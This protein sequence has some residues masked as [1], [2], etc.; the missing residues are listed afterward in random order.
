MA[1]F[2]TEMNAHQLCSFKEVLVAC[3]YK[4][5]FSIEEMIY[6]YALMEVVTVLRKKLIATELKTTFKVTFTESQALAIYW[7]WQ[8]LN[9]EPV[10]DL[11]N[12]LHMM[13]LDIHQQYS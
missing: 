1:K 3:L 9:T 5:E 13:A 11:T 12:K 8:M 6:K 10:S 7:F 4:W 2:K